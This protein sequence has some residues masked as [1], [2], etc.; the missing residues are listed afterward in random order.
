MPVQPAPVASPVPVDM[1]TSSNDSNPV[2][3][4]GDG[5][6]VVVKPETKIEK[7]LMSALHKSGDTGLAATIPS[8][9]SADNALSN[10]SLLKTNDA[11]DKLLMSIIKN[12]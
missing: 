7:T 3:P 12:A 2:V 1:L 8:L 10:K 4:D 6:F 9:L 11:Y 5:G